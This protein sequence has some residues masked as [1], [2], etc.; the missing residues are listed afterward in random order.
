MTNHHMA[1]LAR[2]VWDIIKSREDNVK[3]VYS[4][5]PPHP[6]PTPKQTIVLNDRIYVGYSFTEFEKYR[7]FRHKKHNKHSIP[8][9]P[10]ILH[11]AVYIN[12]LR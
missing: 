6:T 7:C 9:M 5:L 2:M 3:P 12:D 4:M 1:N 10:E 11:W 8:T